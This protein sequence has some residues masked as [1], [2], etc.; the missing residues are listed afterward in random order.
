MNLSLHRAAGVPDGP[1]AADA[2]DMT[3]AGTHVLQSA[4]ALERERA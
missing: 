3:K 4:K 2:E 1:G